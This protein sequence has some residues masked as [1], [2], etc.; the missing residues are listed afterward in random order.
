[1][2]PIPIY[3]QSPINAAKAAGVTPKT[4]AVENA[5]SGGKPSAL[6]TTTTTT[7]YHQ[8]YPLAQPGATPSLPNPTGIAQN[9]QCGAMQPTPTRK[10]LEGPP[11]PQPGA[12]PIPPGVQSR[13][14]PPPR[15]TESPLIPDK[16]SAAV[17]QAPPYP[18][19]MFIPAPTAPYSQRGTSTA[20]G[21]GPVRHSQPNTLVGPSGSSGLVDSMS[22]PPGYLNASEFSNHQ[23]AAHALLTSD[24]HRSSLGGDGDDGV[25]N[26]AKKWAKAAGDTLSTA[27]EKVWQRINKK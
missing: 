16:G 17:S 18:P 5:I 23:R 20:T 25:W 12:V 26:S 2:P 3:T 7:Q 6:A 4:P 22:H 1:M 9:Q 13:G 10:Q 27:E 19:Q 15:A 21:P 24:R 14:P 8:A 11:R